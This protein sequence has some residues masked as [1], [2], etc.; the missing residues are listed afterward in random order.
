MKHSS[1]SAWLIGHKSNVAVEPPS[2]LHIRKWET[3]PTCKAKTR[4]RVFWAWP[5]HCAHSLTVYDCLHTTCTRSDQS[6][7][8]RRLGEAHNLPPWAEEV[9]IVQWLL[10]KG[11]AGESQ[12][13]FFL[14]VCPPIR[15]TLLQWIA[16]HHTCAYMN[17]TSYMCIY[18]QHSFFY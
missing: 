2:S 17:S 8:R 4:S 15:P 11:R 12:F 3:T 13:F 5:N 1:R 6:A 14:R 10:L 16:A 18:E 7:L 9:L